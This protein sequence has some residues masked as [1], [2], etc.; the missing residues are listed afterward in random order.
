MREFQK[1]LLDYWREETMG[2]FF[3]KFGEDM[4]EF[5]KSNIGGR[6]LWGVFP[7]IWSRYARISKKTISAGGNYGGIFP[8]IC[9]R[10]AR[11]LKKQYWR[12][13]TMEEF[14]PELAEGMREF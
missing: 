4:R 6:K 11:I 2:E 3:Q 1:T 14:F 8:K 9:S 12:E 5:L 7:E 10:D 13:E